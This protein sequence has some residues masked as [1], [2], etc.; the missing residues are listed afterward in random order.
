VVCNDTTCTRSVLVVCSSAHKVEVTNEQTIE[1]PQ[2]GDL[3]N[4][5]SFLNRR[6]QIGGFVCVCVVLFYLTVNILSETA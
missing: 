2:H 1:Y 3:V 4:P 6:E 5:C